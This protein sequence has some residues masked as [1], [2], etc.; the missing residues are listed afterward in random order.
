MVN[1]VGKTTRIL[2]TNLGST[3]TFESDNSITIISVEL[4]LG[5]L[6]FDEEGTLGV[7]SNYTDN[8][9]FIVTTYA[10]SIDIPTILSISY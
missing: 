4:G 6:L 1:N 9:N 10:L 2:N 3:N 7:I 8:T 5:C